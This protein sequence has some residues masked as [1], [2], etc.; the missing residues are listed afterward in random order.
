MHHP[1]RDALAVKVGHLVS[2]DDVLHQQ[3]ASGSSRLN[4]QLIAYGNARSR[5]QHVGS[6]KR[7][8]YKVK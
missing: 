3:G 7:N 6:L 1:F 8:A 2:E 5:G 4:I